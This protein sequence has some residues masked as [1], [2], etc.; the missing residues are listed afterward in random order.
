M[1][2]VLYLQY[3]NPAYFPPLQQSSRILANEGWEVRFVGSRANADDKMEFPLHERVEVLLLPFV[4]PGIWQKLN[5]LK[6]LLW[7]VWQLFIW[8]PAWVY[9]SDVMACPIGWLLSYWPGVR[10]LYHEHDSPTEPAGNSFQRLTLAARRHLAQQA[11]LCVLPNER[12]VE[13]FLRETGRRGETLCVWNCPAREEVPAARSVAAN[14]E[15]IV[16][17]HGTIVPQRVPRTLLHALAQSPER[18]KLRVIGYTTIG[19]PRYVEELQALAAALGVAERVEFVGP[20]SRYELMERC[21]EADVGVSVFPMPLDDWNEQTMPG[22]SC[23]AFDYLACGLPLLVSD[24]P[25]WRWM[26]VENGYAQAC[27][28]N[29]PVSIAAALSWYWE[30]RAEMQAMGE[31]G[32]Q[33]IASEWNYE[34]Q[35]APVLAALQTL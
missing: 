27:N 26:F 23:K 34:S 11:A 2:R 29:D 33:K 35:F 12:R 10:I 25:E 16:L 1:P 17:Y 4:P 22:A 14:D 28:V 24:L 19:A 30:N 15:M 18:V 7:S 5:Y 32:R 6:F 13:R 31:C 3:V 8:R 20:L 9:V 21:R